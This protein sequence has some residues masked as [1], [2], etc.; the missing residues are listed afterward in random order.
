MDKSTTIGLPEI[1]W[2]SATLRFDGEDLNA[3]EESISVSLTI[4]LLLF[5]I[6]IPT[7][8]FPSITSTTLTLLTDNDL[9]I[10]CAILVILLAFVPG[11]GWISNRVTTGPGKTDS[12]VASIPNS[13]N[14]ASR[15]SAI[16]F[17]SLSDNEL[18]SSSALSSNS[19]LGITAFSF[20]SSS[21]SELSFNTSFNGVS[22]LIGKS[23]WVRSFLISSTCF[24]LIWGSFEI[25]GFDAD[26]TL[27]SFLICIVVT[28]FLTLL[29]KRINNSFKFTRSLEIIWKLN[30]PKIIKISPVL[31]IVFNQEKLKAN[32]VEGINNITK[33]INDP[34]SP[35]E[36]DNARII[37]FPTTPPKLSRK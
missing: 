13:S 10:S 11:A 37:S 28:I 18:P 33:N 19:V 22:S 36:E 24:S 6:S 16:W 20:F 29:K 25:L 1:S 2:P 26:L 35:I 12:T 23:P 4:F 30:F 31:S 15:S 5:G 27:L 3:F 34:I 7:Y 9:A 8:D 32:E 14:L 21:V 17:N